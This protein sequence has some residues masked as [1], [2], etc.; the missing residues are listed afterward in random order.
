MGKIS[1]DELNK[2]VSR[3]L[4]LCGF[5]LFLHCTDCCLHAVEFSFHLFAV[6]R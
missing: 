2:S 3:K 4:L 5:N 6:K 1:I